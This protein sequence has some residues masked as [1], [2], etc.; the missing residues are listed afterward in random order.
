MLRN[1]KL[2]WKIM[3]ILII[4]LPVLVGITLYQS[5]TLIAELRTTAENTGMEMAQR[6]AN[7]I[8][9]E[10]SEAMVAARTL[11][12]LMEGL[13]EA[14]DLPQRE[15]FLNTLK[16]FLKD[17]KEFLGVFV[18]MEPDALD[19]KDADYADTPVHEI[20]GAFRPWVFREGATISMKQSNDV[21]DPDDPNASWY[22]IPKNKGRE[23]VMEPWA[24]EINGKNVLMVDMV[25]PM[26]A[27]G[28]F[29]G[30][31]GVDYPMHTIDAYVRD[32]K[33]FQSG[34][35]VLLSN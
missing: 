32:V 16:L 26:N 22:H 12:R 18:S 21:S 23:I 15:V 1:L 34:Y 3:L 19:G 9:T 11:A 31:A 14:K 29:L 24:Y 30:V 8:D 7:K 13:A 28:A 4:V 2:K 35:A 6:Y 5:H 33:V 27:K 17:H 25:V 10:M 20:D